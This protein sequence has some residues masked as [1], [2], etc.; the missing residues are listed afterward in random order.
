MMPSNRIPIDFCCLVTQIQILLIYIKNF[1]IFKI[2]ECLFCV[3]TRISDLKIS[4]KWLSFINKLINCRAFGEV[5][6]NRNQLN[7]KQQFNF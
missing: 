7:T 5:G 3:N 6:L 2:T 4:Y 1:N